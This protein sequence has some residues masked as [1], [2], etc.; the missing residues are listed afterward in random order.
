MKSKTGET[1]YTETHRICRGEV[2]EIATDM[3]EATDKDVSDYKS[4]GC[5]HGDPFNRLVYT[6]PGHPHDILK[7][8]VCDTTLGYI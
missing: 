4:R 6:I 3:V 8:G 1:L 2:C 5:N 7:C